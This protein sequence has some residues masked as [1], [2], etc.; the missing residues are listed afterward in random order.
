[1]ISPT[2]SA[3]STPHAT[4]LS[5][6]PLSPEALSSSGD[7]PLYHDVYVTA[8]VMVPMPVVYHPPAPVAYIRPQ[9]QPVL[10]T[11]M[12]PAN[13]R[14]DHVVAGVAAGVAVGVTTVAV[15]DCCC[16]W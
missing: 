10:A 16:G 14:R 12:P 3:T 1:M 11:H 2:N 6:N 4:T 8:P 9:P 7:T 13:H 15:A 5:V